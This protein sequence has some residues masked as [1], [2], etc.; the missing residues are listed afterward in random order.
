MIV[1]SRLEIEEQLA[2][3]IASDLK[4]EIEEFGDA[5]LLVSGGSTPKGLFKSLCIKDIPWDKVRISLVDERFLPNGSKDQNGSLIKSYLLMNRAAKAT[6]FPMVL[7]PLNLQKNLELFKDSLSKIRRPFTVVVLGMGND[8]HTAS[9]FPDSDELDKA[10]EDPNNDEV[11]ITHTDSS[12]YARITFSFKA[13]SKA[14]HLYLHFYGEEKHLILE[15]AKGKSGHLPYP[16]QKFLK[17]V[18]ELKIY[19]T[20]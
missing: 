20:S 4:S 2:A 12:P 17:E 7:D 18:D 1:K 16:I 3:R 6:F 8:G 13:L 5:S 9:F 19:S 14:K 11:L 15:K 10:I